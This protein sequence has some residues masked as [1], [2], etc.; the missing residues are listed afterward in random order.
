M[1]RKSSEPDLLAQALS[2]LGKLTAGVFANQITAFLTQVATVGGAA[3]IAGLSG[4]AGAMVFAV[5]GLFGITEAWKSA[6]DKK[7]AARLAGEFAKLKGDQKSAL[8]LINDIADGKAGVTLDWFTEEQLKDRIVAGLAS[9][10]DRRFRRVDRAEFQRGIEQR[11]D[12]G[13]IKSRSRQLRD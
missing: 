10:I 11:A 12:R 5:A 3:A 6:K 1:S 9:A 4:P 13:G 7:K 8:Q 2:P